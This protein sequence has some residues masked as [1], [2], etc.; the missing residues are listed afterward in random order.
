MKGKGLLIIIGL[1]VVLAFMLGGTYNKLAVLDESIDG[2]W[3]QVENQLKRRA[4]LIPNLVNTVKGYTTY[5][6]EVLTKI[7][8]ARAGIDSARTPQ[9][10]AQADAELG[11]ALN[12][13]NIVVENYPDL[14]ASP[15]FADLQAE[16]AGTEN[17]ITTERMRYNEVVRDYNTTIRRF[18]T[19][20]MAGIFNF[21]NRQ[22][23]EI[24]QADAEVPKVE[25]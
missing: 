23:F 20:I 24:N 3:A 19:N 5:E 14:K 8:N 9:E 15:L 17:R 16:L 25:F 12:N 6:E 13:L 7:T 1:I 18:P 4:D 10:F 22:Y 2:S 21:D 11:T